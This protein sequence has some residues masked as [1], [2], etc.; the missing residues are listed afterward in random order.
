M[1]MLVKVSRTVRQRA[2]AARTK[3]C[4]ELP[5]FVGKTAF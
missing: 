5:D 4:D 2:H 1:T 3:L